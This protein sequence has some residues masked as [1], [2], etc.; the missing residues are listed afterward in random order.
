MS[1]RTE[2]WL[3]RHRLTVDDYYRMGE[4]GVLAQDARVEL[5]NGEI[6]DMVPP[7]S[8]HAAYVT[9]LTQAFS[10]AVGKSAL[11]SVQSPL[12]LNRYS[13]PQPDLML[14]RPRDDFYSK[15]HP[16]P[17]DALLVVEVSE[18]S[19]RYDRQIKMPLYAS[20]EIAEFWLIDLT[21]MELHV[22]RR[23]EHG[24]YGHVAVMSPANLTSLTT[25]TGL[26]VDLIRLF[27]L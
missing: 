21:A 24:S 8:R 10:L 6:I 20:H 18:S 26:T 22:C 23:P 14:L 27:E 12:R 1:V 2:D 13:E 19:L 16:G 5:I 25:A 4:T 11:V 3:P 9:L 7:G 17:A 15:A